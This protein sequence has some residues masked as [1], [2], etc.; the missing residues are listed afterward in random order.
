MESR[1]AA[2]NHS[3][4]IVRHRSEKDMDWNTDVSHFAKTWMDFLGNFGPTVHEE[5]RELA[6]FYR[7]HT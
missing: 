2:E 3:E 1:H 5:S 4:R 7:R 6:V